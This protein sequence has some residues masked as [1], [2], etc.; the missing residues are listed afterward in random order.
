[1][2]LTLSILDNTLPCKAEGKVAG[3]S[4]DQNGRIK[5][6]TNGGTRYETINSVDHL[7]SFI[8]W[9]FHFACKGL[10][11]AT[12]LKNHKDYKNFTAFYIPHGIDCLVR[13]GRQACHCRCCLPAKIVIFIFQI[14]KTKLS[15]GNNTL[16][17]SRNWLLGPIG[18]ASASL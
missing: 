4:V 16:Y 6:K 10:K 18:P 1:M 3:Y 14:N 9:W 15:Y 2:V 11:F 13:M 5:I 12:F 7:N 8:K 17:T